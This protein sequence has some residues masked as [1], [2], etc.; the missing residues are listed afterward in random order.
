MLIAVIEV[1][2]MIRW[3]TDLIGE[4][5]HQG[6]TSARAKS[7]EAGTRTPQQANISTIRRL[8]TSSI[9]QDEFCFKRQR[10]TRVR[11]N[12]MMFLVVGMILTT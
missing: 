6:Y 9:R 7:S 12:M 8:P 4:E 5:I 3:F 2:D 11:A 10:L 1:H